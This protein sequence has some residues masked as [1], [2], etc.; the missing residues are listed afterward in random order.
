M[1]H[2]NLCADILERLTGQPVSMAELFRYD[3]FNGDPTAPNNQ[4]QA[5]LSQLYTE[6]EQRPEPWA[7]LVKHNSGYGILEGGGCG[8]FYAA[9]LVSGSEVNERVAKA[10]QIVLDDERGHG[11]PAIL[12]VDKFITTEEQLEDVKEMLRVRGAQRLRFRNEQF[13][14]PVSEARIAEIADGKIDIG[15]VAEIWGPAFGRYLE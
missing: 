1:N 3:L 7:D 9:S 10:F 4:E 12:E 13:S 2:G 11:L 5:K 8:M 6:Q 15:V 14:Y